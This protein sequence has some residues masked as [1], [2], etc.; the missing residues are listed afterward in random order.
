MPRVPGGAAAQTGHRLSSGT[1][2][3]CLQDRSGGGTPG[4]AGPQVLPCPSW[5]WLISGH[6]EAPL[7]PR[8][9]SVCVCRHEAS[10]GKSPLRRDRLETAPPSTPAGALC[11]RFLFCDLR[12]V[13]PLGSSGSNQ[14]LRASLPQGLSLGTG[15]GTRLHLGAPQPSW[16]PRGGQAGSRGGAWSSN[17]RGRTGQATSTHCTGT[18]HFRVHQSQPRLKSLSNRHAGPAALPA[19]QG[20]RW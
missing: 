14:G 18:R 10:Q 13:L 9:P 11:L 4:S 3:L 20:S 1:A 8:P 12:L 16:L 2:S 19:A 7:P 17:S 5:T 15:D 6:R